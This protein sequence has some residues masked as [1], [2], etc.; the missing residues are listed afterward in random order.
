ME[1]GLKADS[2]FDRYVGLDGFGFRARTILIDDISL[3]KT[4]LETRRGIMALQNGCK[5]TGGKQ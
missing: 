1:N 2:V 3:R 4:L 5:S